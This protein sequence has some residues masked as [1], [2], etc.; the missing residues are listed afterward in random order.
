MNIN[1]VDNVDRDDMERMCLREKQ[2]EK[3][4][5][6]TKKRGE[7]DNSGERDGQRASFYTSRLR[8]SGN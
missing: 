6:Q 7:A 3:E 5:T 8:Y 2:T 1:V 4:E